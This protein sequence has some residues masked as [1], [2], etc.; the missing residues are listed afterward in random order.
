MKYNYTI[1]NGL[2]KIKTNTRK[3]IAGICASIGLAAA[4][5]MPVLAAQPTNPGCF[6]RDRADVLHAMQDGTS[7]Y[8]TG[9]PGASEWGKIA[10]ERA[11]NNGQINR[12]YVCQP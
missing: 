2:T 5:A 9:A 1:E 10:G 7:P 12:D 3:Y 6:G 8:S 4:V 11:G